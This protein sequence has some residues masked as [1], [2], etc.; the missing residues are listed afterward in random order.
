MVDLCHGGVCVMVRF[1]LWWGL[2]HGGII[3]SRRGS[4]KMSK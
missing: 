1:V 3:T 2:C 4:V